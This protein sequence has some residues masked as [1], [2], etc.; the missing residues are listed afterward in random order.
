MEG[1]AGATTPS[2]HKNPKINRNNDIIIT[3]TNNK[4]TTN[5]NGGSGRGD[6][7]GVRQIPLAGSPVG[8][9]NVV[10]ATGSKGEAAA[11]AGGSAGEAWGRGGVCGGPLDLPIRNAAA[12]TSARSAR[13]SADATAAGQA[14]ARRVRT[15]G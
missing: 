13:G 8:A 10:A 7:G 9:T 12:T 3:Y 11:A 6:V 1:R 14:W 5:N 4:Y 15:R 2:S